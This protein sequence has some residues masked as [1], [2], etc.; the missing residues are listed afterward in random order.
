MDIDEPE[1]NQNDGLDDGE[2][3]EDE[4]LFENSAAPVGLAGVLSML[5]Q[6][7]DIQKISDEQKE[8]NVIEKE[9]LQWL[10]EQRKKDAILAREVD[11][12]KES[13]RGKNGTK[14]EA[15]YEFQ[16]RQ[17]ERERELARFAAK[18]FE[19]Y[20]PNIE[21]HYRDVTG[22]D[23]TPKEVY[24]LINCRRLNCKPRNSMGKLVGQRRLK[25]SC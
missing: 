11:R 13:R 15:D 1:S 9:R 4:H 16:N 12:E 8:R 5:S 19:N 21:L 25:R 2:I 24:L 10:T 6:R 18:K 7:G 23:L 14:R 20:Q 22:R 17:A 3:V